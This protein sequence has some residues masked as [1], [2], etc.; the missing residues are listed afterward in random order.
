M[1]PRTQRVQHVHA[2][3]TTQFAS[4][5]DDATIY[6]WDL[7]CVGKILTDAEAEWGPA[8]IIFKHSGHRGSVQVLSVL[9]D[10]VRTLCFLTFRMRTRLHC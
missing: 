9:R 2:C 1:C 8:E 5:G 10:R 3:S 7:S 4:G 6:V